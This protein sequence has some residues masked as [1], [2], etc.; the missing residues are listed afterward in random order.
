MSYFNLTNGI[1]SVESDTSTGSKGALLHFRQRKFRQI[2]NVV[3]AGMMKLLGVEQRLL[4][5]VSAMMLAARLKVQEVRNI[6][7]HPSAVRSVP[8]EFACAIFVIAYRNRCYCIL[9][10]L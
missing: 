7:I 10:I 6:N 2:I 5:E 1:P 4:S 3:G 9:C 8:I